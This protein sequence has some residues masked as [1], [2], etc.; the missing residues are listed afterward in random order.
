MS[1]G[2]VAQ[3]APEN[4]DG[5]A[6][7][8]IDTIRKVYRVTKNA[9]ARWRTL[10]LFAAFAAAVVAG[11][12][13]Q[14]GAFDKLEAKRR[15]I[16]HMDW[17]RREAPRDLENLLRDDTG[18]K[19]SEHSVTVVYSRLVDLADEHGVTRAGAERIAYDLQCDESTVRRA[20]EALRRF[21]VAGC[22]DRWRAPDR[23]RWETGGY[24]THVH[25]LPTLPEPVDD[26]HAPRRSRRRGEAGAPAA[27]APTSSSSPAPRPPP[28]P[29]GPG[30]P[31]GPARP[32]APAPS[33][34]STITPSGRE[35]VLA[36]ARAL[37]ELAE[38][39]NDADADAIACAAKRA[40][41]SEWI[42]KGLREL[43]KKIRD[44][45]IHGVQD[46]R[47]LAC[48]FVRDVL[49]PGESDDER[50]E[51]ELYGDLPSPKVFRDALAKGEEIIAADD[52]RPTIPDDVREDLIRQGMF[53][54]AAALA[55]ANARADEI[56]KAG[57]GPP[58]RPS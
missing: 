45:K 36:A 28:R 38:L 22:F 37:P 3:P 43:A 50:E 51:E 41:K 7:T 13:K 9:I 44:G 11:E 34:R 23:D 29:G 18:R 48:A 30:G 6:Q 54:P 32:K 12:A 26:G 25:Y 24:R 42:G 40:G 10:P 53:K 39:D 20:Q 17:A 5:V 56:D 46:L 49:L 4:S 47:R 27:A 19:V 31:G 55:A 15:F 58:P 16:A 2:D 57:T 1:P 35:A 14:P 33:A 52:V 8:A 21:Q